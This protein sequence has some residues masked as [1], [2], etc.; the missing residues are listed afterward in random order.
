MRALLSAAALSLRTPMLAPELRRGVAVRAMAR[1]SPVQEVYEAAVRGDLEEIKAAMDVLQPSDVGLQPG[2]IGSSP[3]DPVGYHHVHSS[4]AFSIGIFVLP[5]G[6]SL[7]LHDHPGMNVLSKLLFGS[8]RVT[9]Y[10]LPRD[11]PPPRSLFDRLGG[12]Q[13]R[14]LCAAPS[15]H[16]VAAP[17]P[18]LGLDEERGNIHSFEALEHTAIFDVLTP[19]YSDR[20]GRSCHYY[21][22]AEVRDDGSVV[23][24]EVPWPD[25]L[26][27]VNRAFRGPPIV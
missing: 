13:R 20:D 21:E 11:A 27:I 1:P 14:L 26:D 8:L 22:E 25:T 19:P 18:T 23:L 5:P 24:R 15:I 7:P 6:K 12:E 10:D 16:T 2:G 4:G 9:S 17:S 3:G